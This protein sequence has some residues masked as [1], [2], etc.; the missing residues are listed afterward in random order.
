M[1]MTDEQRTQDYGEFLK[2]LR[3]VPELRVAFTMEN[4]QKAREH[5]SFAFRLAPD[6][7]YPVATFSAAIAQLHRDMEHGALPEVEDPHEYDWLTPEWIHNATAAQI[8]GL[9]A[10]QRTKM[11]EVAQAAEATRMAAQRAATA[12]KEVDYAAELE[13]EF[14]ANVA[15]L[16]DITVADVKAKLKAYKEKFG[17]KA[18]EVRDVIGKLDPWATRT[19]Q[20]RWRMERE[21]E[22]AKIEP[23]LRLKADEKRTIITNGRHDYAKTE[24]YRQAAKAFN[25]AKGF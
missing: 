11:E 8:R 21:A 13:A 7:V 4:Y 20:G 12:V 14:K 6:S 9:S 17:G 16:G 25:I 19:A 5:A 2:A 3:L 24:R 22:F 1:S 10:R 15:A 23:L 18:P